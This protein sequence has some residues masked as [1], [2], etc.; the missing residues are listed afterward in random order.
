MRTW[1]F[2]PVFSVLAAIAIAGE[3][4]ERVIDKEAAWEEVGLAREAAGRDEH[5]QAAASFI[6]ALNHDARLVGAV[7]DELAAQKLWNEEHDKAIFYYRRYLARHPGEDNREVRRNLALAYSW[8]GRQGEAITIYRQLVAEDATDLDARLGLGR[9]LI[10]DN[11]LHE[12]F[13]VMRGVETEAAGENAGQAA[14]GFLLTVLDEYDPHLDLSWNRILD[15]DDLTIDR[16]TGLGRLNLGNV[17]AQAGGSVA[18]YGQ[19][20]QPDVTAPRFQ[21][22]VVAPLAHNWALHA[23]AWVENY[24]SDGPMPA[25]GEDL[26]WT[27]LGG[28]AWLTWLA[29]SRLR[30]DLGAGSHVVET[31]FALANRLHYE[32]VALSADWRFA[33]AWTLSGAGQY[34]GYSDGNERRRGSLQLMWQR[35]GLWEWTAGPVF[36]YMDY[37]IPYPG[38]YW[39]PDWVRNGSLSLKLK[40]R[41]SRVIAAV[42]GSYGL[43]KETGADAVAVGGIHGHVG[44]RFHAAWLVSTDLGYSRSSFTSDSGYNRTTISI[45][46]RALF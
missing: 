30:L 46:L 12:G 8:S 5:A 25:S 24:T 39:A 36:Y 35:P 32:P 31:Y 3:T 1:F 40:R 34:A 15:S 11:R 29:T 21:L 23:Y 14:A 13:L 43:E 27:R 28:D 16:V 19:P 45:R 33:R 44:W 42:D 2:I 41:W 37:K 7:S 9:V 17:L 38:G 18:R 26:D 20:D 22:G 4:G 10:W 6:A